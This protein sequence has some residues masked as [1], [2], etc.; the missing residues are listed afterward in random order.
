M[1]CCVDADLNDLVFCCSGKAT[2]ISLSVMFF[3]TGGAL[4][5][6]IIYQAGSS[7]PEAHNYYNLLFIPSTFILSTMGLC[8][9]LAFHKKIVLFICILWPL[10]VAGLPGYFIYETYDKYYKHRKALTGS[11]AAHIAKTNILIY[12]LPI[13]SA[14][15]VLLSV[16]CI[17]MLC[18]LACCVRAEGGRDR[19]DVF[20]L[21][22]G[23][24]DETESMNGDEEEHGHGH[25]HRIR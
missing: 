23:M 9:L 22:Y 13:C 7:E 3:I 20:S 19:E 16:Y 6:S 25:G 2:A 11:A 12:M 4:A 10:I 18:C 1:S 8:L 15:A 14:I 24:T 21:E 5:G 17:L